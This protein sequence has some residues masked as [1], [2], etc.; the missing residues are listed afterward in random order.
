MAFGMFFDGGGPSTAKVKEDEF[1][2]Q[3]KFI[4]GQFSKQKQFMTALM[5]KTEL[6]SV[7]SR[8]LGVLD[9]LQ[10]RYEFISS[11]EGF[12][13]CLKENVAAE[14]TQRVEYF[15]DQSDAASVKHTFDAICPD[16]IKN[17][18]ASDSQQVC[19]FLMYTYVVIEQRRHEIMTIMLSLLA[20]DEN[21]DQLSL[22][23]LNVEG[24]QKKSLQGWLMKTL[25]KVETYCGLFVYHKAIWNGKERELRELM[26]FIAFI[27]PELKDHKDKCEK[28]GRYN[29]FKNIQI[30]TG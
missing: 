21:F 1:A 3:R 13:S 15:M 7:K 29:G 20:N 8:A 6:E 25:G 27:A 2:K 26:E 14:I 10:S 24:H 30:C 18:T 12:G 11:Y 5:T 22:G 23:Y 16:I 4:E 9:A 19:A 17:S 28:L